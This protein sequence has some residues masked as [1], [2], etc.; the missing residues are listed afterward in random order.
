[1]PESV[2]FSPDSAIAFAPS[3]ISKSG[4]KTP[5]LGYFWP[6]CAGK[7]KW[8]LEIAGLAA[9]DIENHTA[10]HLEAVQTVT[11]SNTDSTK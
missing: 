8:G 5:G 1:M 11:D 3:Y 9:I 10:F 7:A 4:K 2:L 6:G